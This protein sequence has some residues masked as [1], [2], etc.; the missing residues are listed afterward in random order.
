VERPKLLLFGAPQLERAGTRVAIERRKALA[1]LAYLATMPG[2]HARDTLAALLWPEADATQARAHLSRVLVDLRQAISPEAL[3][4]DVDR[5][6][7][8][9]DALFVDTARFRTCLAQVAAHHPTREPLCDA[10]LAA[11]AEAVDLYRGDF[12]AGFTLRDAPDFDTW[13]TYTGETLRLELG[14]ALE[15]LALAHSSRDAF[16]RALPHARRWL[17]LD[18]LCEPAHRCLMRLYAGLGDRAAAFA[19]YEACTKALQGELGIL[20]EPETTALYEQLKAGLVPRL[21]AEIGAGGSVALRPA[22]LHPVNNL[23]APGSTFFGREAELEEIAARLGDPACRLLTILGPG[24]IGKTRL[25]IEV[26]RDSLDRFPHG[27]CFV[28]LVSASAAELVASVVLQALGESPAGR[29]SPQEQ[30]IDYLARRQLLLIL[31]N[32]EHLLAVMP[33]TATG[34]DAATLLSQ[35]LEAAPG[36]KLIVTSRER[37]NLHDEWLLPLVGLEVPAQQD[38]V[39]HAGFRED[40]EPEA[41]LDLDAHSATRFFFHCA[42][43]VRPD[44]TPDAGDARLIARICR[45]VSGIPLAIELVAPWLR[46]LPLPEIARRLEQGLDLLAS[47]QRDVPPRHRS[48]RAAF[49][50][51][52]RLLSAHE[53]A[54]L[55]CSSVFRGGFTA[56]AALAVADASLTDLSALVDRSWLSMQPTGRYDLHELVRQYCAEKLKSEHLA[57]SSETPRDVRERH[58]DYYIEQLD[59]WEQACRAAGYRSVEL[60]PLDAELANVE[61]AWLRALETA[62]LDRIARIV[63]LLAL[64]DITSDVVRFQRLVP[65]V[66][67]KLRQ[68]YDAAT[69]QSERSTLIVQRVAMYPALIHCAPWRGNLARQR[70]CLA[71][72]LADLAFADPN[73]QDWEDVDSSVRWALALLEGH[74]GDRAKG[75]R[76][77]AELSGSLERIHS[78]LWPYRPEITF[79]VNQMGILSLQAFNLLW[80]GEYARGQEVTERVLASTQGAGRC[81]LLCVLAELLWSQGDY[82]RSK[83]VALE[84][85]R[86]SRQESMSHWFAVALMEL[87]RIETALNEFAA[88]REH[89]NQSAAFYRS[90]FYAEGMPA[91]LSGLGQVELQLR[92]PDRATEFFE[93]SLELSEHY[94]GEDGAYVAIALLGLGQAAAALQ[95]RARATDYF[96]RA[97][98]VP[99]RLGRTSLE[100]IASMAEIVGLEGDPAHAA[101]LLAFVVD[102]RYT[103]HWVRQSAGKLLAELEA[104]LPAELLAAAAAR[105]RARD[106]ADVEAEIRGD[107]ASGSRDI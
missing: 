62:H 9:P 107:G 56:E 85:I 41:T 76:I 49:D 91:A 35:W 28:S 2:A 47:G 23:P 6:A 64:I 73:T 69:S 55:R 99:P 90:F 14:E 53:R 42:R 15:S 61:D 30:V 63:P 70:V 71:E 26:G 68:M 48:M 84:A 52:W 17:G 21:R 24:G 93:R 58:D 57:E 45:Q 86:T 78:K 13:Q 7:L 27:V 89:F 1:L 67:D 34:D 102:H 40:M 74:R 37:L 101:E 46:A 44:Y 54:I 98:R 65:P 59:R 103:P 82:Q 60:L 3:E 105:G 100:V 94:Q 19:Q 32:F 96:R 20:P 87:G 43:R 22:A 10:C 83:R 29:L 31:D 79:T 92:R 72:G 39:E 33:A 50:Q 8:H 25:A 12:L 81:G 18:P 106:L 16:E 97:L 95:E 11:L 104:E 75:F 88:A 38:A 5:V 77:L 4:A 36:L 51:S 80:Q 66:V